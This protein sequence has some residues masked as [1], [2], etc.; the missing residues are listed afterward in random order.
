VLYT[1]TV[2]G[3]KR[4]GAAALGLMLAVMVFLTVAGTT[5]R[6]RGGDAAGAVFVPVGSPASSPG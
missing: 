6:P 5:S 4:T 3:R 2:E 1:V